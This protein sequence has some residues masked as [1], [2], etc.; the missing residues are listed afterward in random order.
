MRVIAAGLAPDS[1][2]VVRVMTPHPDTALPSTSILDALKKMHGKKK[3]ERNYFITLLITFYIDGHYLNLPVLDEERNIVGLIDVLRLTYA[4]LEQV[5]K[6]KNKMKRG[7]TS[8][9]DQ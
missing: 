7:I 3:K 6:K 5:Q 8:K 2:S 9:I 1:C 4:T